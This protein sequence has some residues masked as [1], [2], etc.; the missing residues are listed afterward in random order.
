MID[1][2]FLFFIKFF[3]FISCTKLK[4]QHVILIF[5]GIG[6]TCLEMYG[7]YYLQLFITDWYNHSLDFI[8]SF[9][10]VDYSSNDSQVLLKRLILKDFKMNICNEDNFWKFKFEWWLHVIIVILM[11]FINKLDSMVQVFKIKIV[12]KSCD[13]DDKNPTFDMLFNLQH[14]STWL[15]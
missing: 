4:H 10:V 3:G 5:K 1:L 8:C 12:F 9:L 6:K 15:C 2:V 7:F 14:V 13:N 11:Q